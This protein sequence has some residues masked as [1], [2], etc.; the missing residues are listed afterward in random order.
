ME[1]DNDI[2]KVIDSMCFFLV[3]CA[4]DLASVADDFM[5]TL[6]TMVCI[7]CLDASHSPFI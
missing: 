3:E 1:I 7:R 2:E 5:S 4:Y 6:L